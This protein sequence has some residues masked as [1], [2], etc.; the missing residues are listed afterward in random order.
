MNNKGGK[1]KE[2]NIAFASGSFGHYFGL[3]SEACLQAFQGEW[4]EGE[5]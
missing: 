3:W 5:V 2:K 4:K 1:V